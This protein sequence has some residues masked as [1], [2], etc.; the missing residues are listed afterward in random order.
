MLYRRARLRQELAR[1][2]HADAVTVRW[3]SYELMPEGSPDEGMARDVLVRLR[4]MSP[5]QVARITAHVTEVAAA[6]GLGLTTPPAPTRSCTWQP[7][8]VSRT[9]S[10]SGCCGRTSPTAGCSAT[11]R[12]GRPGRRGRP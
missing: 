5:E 3:R 2:A 7:S 12:L 1:F 8:T 4:G 9:R 10:R 6:E 11:R